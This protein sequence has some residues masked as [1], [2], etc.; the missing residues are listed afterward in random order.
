MKITL[1]DLSIEDVSMILWG[2]SLLPDSWLTWLEC[3]IRNLTY[4]MFG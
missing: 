2:L 3:V 1:G 4:R